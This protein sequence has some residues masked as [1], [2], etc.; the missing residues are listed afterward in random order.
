MAPPDAVAARMRSIVD[1][2]ILVSRCTRCLVRPA[3]TAARTC[4][5]PSSPR[6]SATG[7]CAPPPVWPAAAVGGV[8]R[9][10]LPG[11]GHR[12]SSPPG[13]GSPPYPKPPD[14]Q[15]DHPGDQRK[16]Q[17]LAEPPAT[18]PPSRANVILALPKSR[19]TMRRGKRL[20]LVTGQRE[21]SGLEGP[22]RYVSSP[23]SLLTPTNHNHYDHIHDLGDLA[24]AALAARCLSAGGPDAVHLGDE[25][26]R[27]WEVPWRHWSAGSCRV[28]RCWPRP[29]S[30]Q[31]AA[32]HPPR[33][34][35]VPAAL[36]R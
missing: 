30:P 19:S 34:A 11:P 7:S 25:P 3:A 26:Y 36:E 10:P 6:P 5:S 22:K 17:G 20:R 32:A 23:A 28:W 21:S 16:E 33:E 24:P 13:S 1:R 9:S 35:R 12:R 29:R 18:R 14:Q 31:L 27:N 2:P 4:V 15:P 8:S